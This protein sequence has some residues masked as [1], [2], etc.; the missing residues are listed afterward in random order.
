[1]PDGA[2]KAR[3]EQ[4]ALIEGYIHQKLVSSKLKELIKELENSPK[5][6]IVDA[7]LLRE[8]KREH[9]IATKIPEDLV[10]EIARA[11]TI[12]EKAWEKAKK[13]SDFKLFLPHLEKMV[14]LQK[15]YAELI[16]LGKTKYDSLLDLYEQGAT[17][18]VISKVFGDL[19]PKLIK[20]LDKLDSSSNKPD[21]T[22]LKKVY[23]P[24]KQ[25][26]LSMEMLKKLNFNFEFGRQ[27]KSIHPFTTTLA[28][29]DTR[30]TTRITNNFFSECLFSTIHECGHALY[31]MGY[32]EKIYDTT[33]ADGSSYGIHESQSRL[34][35]N[36]VGRSRVFWKYWY[37]I[38]QNYF[39]EHLKNY[40]EKEFYRAINLV[41]RSFIR[42]EADEVTYGLH[43]IL[44]F[45]LEQ[46]IINNAVQIS[47]LP[48]IWNE[49]ME[50]LLEITPLKDSEGVLQ[51][52]HWSGGSFGY[53]PTYT[54]GNLYASQ[55]YA[56]A[57]KK[58][59]SLEED[60]EKGDYSKLL[61]YLRE[62]IHQYGKIYKPL[63]LLKRVTGESMNPNY[64]T[65]YLEKKFYTIYEV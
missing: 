51:D 62:N 35:E 2:S 36:I 63:D 17:S 59:P 50:Q 38:V 61:A 48:S 16:A 13:A 46:E 53:F 9:E 10:K 12:G 64:F 42:T 52:V 29:T 3:A 5:L 6:D 22:I 57:T 30:I 18:S 65:D 7:A 11:A 26:A 15:K 34:W 56:H 40:P 33:L 25:W 21:P 20:I 58:I 47:E 41:E 8:T 24:E 1:M 55:I 60:F 32:M 19:K 23:N 31:E 45:E 54:L 49:K 39:P 14:K 27:D 37:P 44:R 4:I 28:S 43:V